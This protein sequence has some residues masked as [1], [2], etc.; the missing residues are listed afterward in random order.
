MGDN[1]VLAKV[2][3]DVKT[4][5][6]KAE[7]TWKDS[8]WEGFVKKV[9]LWL[10]DEKEEDGDDVAAAVTGLIVYGATT[11][12]KLQKVADSK[13]KFREA[14]SA[15]GVPEAICDLLFEQYVGGESAGKKKRTGSG[16]L[17]GSL[18]VKRQAVGEGRFLASITK[19]EML[20]SSVHKF[21]QQI[22]DSGGKHLL[23]NR[24]C[25]NPLYKKVVD[26]APKLDAVIVTGTSGI[27]K[28]FL[29]VST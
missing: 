18:A 3:A 20:S 28:T 8:K 7:K 29:G 1:S 11:E 22:V 25:Y 16:G 14:L 4:G 13:E 19:C 24:A 21:P 12:E 9:A 23:F 2:V 6:E 5:L 10:L 15:K 27:G 26:L 17:D